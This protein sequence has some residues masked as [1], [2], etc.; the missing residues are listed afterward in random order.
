MKTSPSQQT[1]SGG[2]DHRLVRRSRVVVAVTILA[3]LSAF[4]W[5]VWLIEEIASWLMD[6]TEEIG[7][8]VFAWSKVPPKGSPFPPNKQI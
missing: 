7:E 3:V 4:Y 8:R 2:S 1:P 6:R 5:S